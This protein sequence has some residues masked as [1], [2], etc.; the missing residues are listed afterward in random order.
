LKL[1]QGTEH[2]TKSKRII[3]QNPIERSNPKNRKPK[4]S[5]CIHRP[6]VV[7]WKR[8]HSVEDQRFRATRSGENRRPG[9]RFPASLQRL[10]DEHRTLG[11]VAVLLQD[12]VVIRVALGLRGGIV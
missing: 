1:N 2:P 4:S 10:L 3:Q 5:Y 12:G 11:G 7:D 8:F 9:R 6:M